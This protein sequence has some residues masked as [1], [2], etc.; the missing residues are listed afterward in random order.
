M[1]RIL[2][3]KAA[4]ASQGVARAPKPAT[5]LTIEIIRHFVRPDQ[6]DEQAR[7]FRSSAFPYAAQ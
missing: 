7:I 5:V 4:G 2:Y 6:L 3:Y 1:A